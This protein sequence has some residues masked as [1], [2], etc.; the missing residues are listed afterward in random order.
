[1]ATGDPASARQTLPI[2]VKYS[3]TMKDLRAE[4]QKVF[5]PGRT[6][7]RVLYQ[8]APGSP[9]GTMYEVVGEVPLV[10]KP[11]TMVGFSQQEGGTGPSSFGMAP[12]ETHSVGVRR[13]STGSVRTGRDQSPV[14]RTSDRSRTPDPAPSPNRGRGTPTRAPPTSPADGLKTSSTPQPLSKAVSSRDPWA[15]LSSGRRDPVQHLGD[16]QSPPRS[17]RMGNTVSGTPRSGTPRVEGAG[18]SEEDIAPSPNMRRVLTRLQ[19]ASEMEG[20]SAANSPGSH[21]KEGAAQKKHW[22]S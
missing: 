17:V 3:R 22:S 9:T 7:R 12:S 2:L 10:Q 13:K 1:M 20:S 14:R 15:T 16:D 6:P 5:P 4:I 18:D 8:G 11:P 19:R 21:T